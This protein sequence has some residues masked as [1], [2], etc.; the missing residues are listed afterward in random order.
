MAAGRGASE[1]CVVAPPVCALAHTRAR[2]SP[3]APSPLP[4]PPPRPRLTALPPPPTHTRAQPVLLET[5]AL[6]SESVVKVAAGARH[7][8]AL[9]ATG[10]AFAWGFGH[11]GQLGTGA[12]AS[13]AAPQPVALPPA[14]KV[15]D[16]AAGWWH[17]L[18]LTE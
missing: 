14:T 6:A 1:V 8:V 3:L 15:V 18:L 5:P 4:P 9:T 11:F 13:A 2:G 10:R 17:T 16:V 12:Y 7:S